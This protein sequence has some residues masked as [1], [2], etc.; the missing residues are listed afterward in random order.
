MPSEDVNIYVYFEKSIYNITIDENIVNGSV[1]V[2]KTKASYN[3]EIEINITPDNDY[4]I[5]KIYLNGVETE[6]TKFLMP[7]SDVNVFVTFKSNVV[8][9]ECTHNYKENVLKDPTC[10][11][12]GIMQYKCNLCGDSYSEVISK[13]DHEYKNN[14]CIHCG[15]KI[16]RS[17]LNELFG[18][19]IDIYTNNEENPYNI[20]LNQYG[21]DVTAYFYEPNLSSSLDPYKNVSETTFYNNYERATTY[22]DAYFRTQHYLMSGDITEQGHLPTEGKLVQDNKAIR[23]TDATYVLDTSGN[24]LAYIPNV[25]NVSDYII[26][27]GAAYTS[28]NDVAAYLLAFGSTPANQI[29]NKYNTSDAIDL[30]GKYG[31]VNDSQFSGDITKYPYEP[32]LP[33]IMGSDSIRYNEMDFGTKGGYIN[34]N[35]VGTYYDQKIYNNG[36]KIDRGAA[37]FVYVSDYNVKSINERYVF[38]TYNHYND[39]QEYLNYHDGWGY[40]F[41]SMTAGNEYCGGVKDYGKLNCVPPTDYPQVIFEK[42]INIIN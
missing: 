18:D 27:Y 37:R 29:A 4:I 9:E 8:N 16:A 10:K 11:E 28:L 30:W 14:E 40:R 7:D 26:F 3:D 1:K 2:N 39:F 34:S 21:S 31:R 15:D 42:S 17:Y 24:Y 41:G 20:D 13:I 12:E 36:S 25:L 19:N 23:F 22:E 38:Y 33:N 6:D 32:L 5:E 35:S